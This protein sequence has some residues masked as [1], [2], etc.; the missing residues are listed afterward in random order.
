MGNP[1]LIDEDKGKTEGSKLTF[2]MA[3]GRIVIENKDR[4]R[5][6]TVIKS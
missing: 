3:D 4:E 1:I 5:S 2:Y 6:E